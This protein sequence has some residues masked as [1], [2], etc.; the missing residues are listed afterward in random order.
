MRNLFLLISVAGAISAGTTHAAMTATL[1][2]N[3][4]QYSFGNGGEFRAVASADLV[5]A[6]MNLQGYS[7]LT[8]G[9][10]SAATD[11]SSWGYK[12]SQVGSFYFQ[13]FCIEYNEHFSPGVTYTAGISTKARYGGNNPNGDPI[14]IGTAWLYSQFAAGTL[15]GYN[16]VYGSGRQGATEAGALQKAIWWLENESNGSNTGASGA[17]ITAAKNGLAALGYGILTDT[18]IRTMD[19][20][21]AFGVYA[22]NLGAPGVVQDQLV[23]VVPEAST[24]IAG[25]LLLLPLGATVVRILGKSQKRA[26]MSD[27]GIATIR[28]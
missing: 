17:F 26:R 16:Y 6:T 4:S 25:T 19:A 24:I 1:L 28:A 11:G 2:D 10:I 22:L 13:T 5:A 3:T 9:I 18:T 27:A 20:N 12:A 7:P 21:G 8:K 14:S 15:T 23:V